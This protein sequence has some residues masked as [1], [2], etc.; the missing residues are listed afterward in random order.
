VE[1]DLPYVHVVHS[2]LEGLKLPDHQVKLS[3]LVS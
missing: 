1:K 2:S 3:C